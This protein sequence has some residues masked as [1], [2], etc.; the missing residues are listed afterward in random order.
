MQD[1]N[2]RDLFPPTPFHLTSTHRTPKHFHLSRLTMPSD[3]LSAF[4]LAIVARCDEHNRQERSKSNFR[5]CVVFEGHFIKYGSH[6]SLYPQ[7]KTQQYIANLADGDASAPHVP[8]VHNYFT[9]EDKMAYLV[10]EYIEAKP[11]LPRDTPEKV[12]E[13]LQW[14]RDLPAPSDVTIGPVGGG[15]ARHKLFKNYTAPLRFS[16][17]EALERYMNKVRPCLSRFL[18]HSPPANQGLN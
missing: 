18:K 5:R 16:S 7:Y 2:E 17:I 10:M 11:T 8:K 1:L 6:R 15:L 9:I 4:Q 13:A 12:A 3:T 14:L